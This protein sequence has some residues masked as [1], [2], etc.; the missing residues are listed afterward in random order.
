MSTDVKERLLDPKRRA[1]VDHKYAIHNVGHKR[2]DTISKNTGYDIELWKPLFDA[3]GR[4]LL[5]D[6]ASNT[7]KSHLYCGN[8]IYLGIRPEL[9]ANG[10]IIPGAASG[11]N[12]KKV[13]KGEGK[14]PKTNKA[15]KIKQD[16]IIR[17]IKKDLVSF[18]QSI[19]T[20]PIPSVKPIVF[21]SKFVELI[22]VR[23]M[24]QCRNLIAKYDAVV[25]E[26][27]ALAASKWTKANELQKR[28]NT[29][30]Y[31]QR[32]LIELIVG[33]NKIISEKQKNTQI[34][35]IC[36][37]DLMDWVA[38]A[39]K[40]INFSASEVI[41]TMPELIFKTVYDNMLEH[42]QI[43]LYQSQKEIFQFVTT[44]ESYLALVHTMLA[45]GKTSMILPLCARMIANRTTEKKKILFGCPNDVVLLEVAHMVYGM[46]VPFA[47]VIHNSSNNTLVYKCSTFC[48]KT[49]LP[50]NATADE[51][52]KAEK[53]KAEN[54]AVLYLCDMFV[55]RML[56][57]ERLQ[58]IEDK[59]K[60]LLA[61][62]RDHINNPLIEQ[63]IPYVPNYIL[64]CDEPTKDADNNDGFMVNSG[65][66]VITEVFVDVIKMA[67]PEV[68]LMSATLPTME[69]LS[70]FY[71]SIVASNPGMVVK[72]FAS[73]E[74][75]IGCA[76]VSSQ[77]ELYAP[78]MGSETVDDIRHILNVIR[79][80]PFVG[81][82]YTFEVLLEM[83]EVFTHLSLPVP[84]LSIMFDDPS[85]ANQTNIQQTAYMML[86]QLIACGS[87][88]GPACPSG[89]RSEIKSDS[90]SACPSGIKP[91][92]IVIKACQMKKIVGNG[93]D[94]T[95]MLTTDI[96]RFN[97]GCLVF[98]SDPV[99][100]AYQVYQANF[101]KFLDKTTD[102]NIFQQVRLDNILTKYHREME[103]FSK[104][105]RRI[106]EKADDGPTKLAS[107][108]RRKNQEKSAE[109]VTI[110]NRENEVKKEQGR[111]DAWQLTSKMLDQKPTWEFPLELQICS[112][113]HIKK[114][115]CDAIPGM[116]GLV[117]PEDLPTNSSVS[118][119]ILT[120][121]A[122]GIGIYSTTSPFLDYEYLQCVLALAKKGI[123]K[124]IFTDSSIAY[125]TN[126]A[127]SDIVMIDDPIE[128]MDG[129]IN[130]SIID[131]HSMKTIFQMLG[132]AGRG[133][134]LSYQA[135]IYTTSNNNEMINRIRFYAKGTLDEGCRD[136]IFNIKRAVETLW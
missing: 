131:K 100:T 54:I 57:E 45:S 15:E 117:E 90:G 97:K 110:Q 30:K 134:N 1:A 59:K 55:A 19:S 116:A 96:G 6:T 120:M 23:M 21:N 94:L 72:S 58:C 104:A 47:I 124:I 112:L 32:E 69:Q 67:P 3:G 41:L 82:F 68:I 71:Q 81:R 128:S 99:A 52:L 111:P 129:T 14:Q 95:T 74:A 103:L 24:V 26:M 107:K 121:L 133:G 61:N 48:G 50:E 28:E 93:V 108:N 4:N 66:S 2:W 85:K 29:K 114:A 87:D 70:K 60:Y 132:R 83:V 35:E 12:I 8:E 13:A 105:L 125:G 44:T 42:R 65:F 49:K 16:N 62:K 119:E 22:L 56:L 118:I 40:T 36:L 77:G 113:E 27:A 115:K 106:E 33:Y 11:K 75:K 135:R 53:L 123:V 91:N 46:A 31:Y 43:G 17:K 20:E 84:D 37:K 25:R 64:M 51:K 101:N 7:A 109:G 38:H 88:S 86:E 10:I 76:L 122:S 5:P 80:N 130:Q 127:V 9:I 34:S 98:S 79:T 18:L 136:E 126:L 73:S 89:I 92:D 39:K 78:H 63:R 102:R